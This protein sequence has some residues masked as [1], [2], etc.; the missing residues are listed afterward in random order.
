M[1][2]KKTV[3]PLPLVSKEKAES[4]MQEQMSA[5]NMFISRLDFADRTLESISNQNNMSSRVSVDDGRLKLSPHNAD[6]VW[7]LAKND[8]EITSLSADVEF[9]SEAE[10][11][12]LGL[13]IELNDDNRIE[14]FRIVITHAIGHCDTGAPSC[15]G[16]YT[17]FITI[18]HQGSYGYT[19]GT[20]A[21]DIDL[22]E[23]AQRPVSSKYIPPSENFKANFTIKFDR[24]AKKVIVKY[25]DKQGYFG[26]SSRF[27][28]FSKVRAKFF[29]E[30][31]GWHVTG[32]SVF[33]DNV[34]INN[35]DFDDFSAPTLDTTKWKTGKFYYSGGY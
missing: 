21:G 32:K 34:K 5:D 33:V 24:A 22:H 27:D 28:D 31:Q 13:L 16:T 1:T 20:L 29:I 12:G 11:S 19:D 2:L 6:N 23:S 7:L 10:I 25:G 30:T 3:E 35:Q 4:H 14:R 15:L 9:V 26:V 8:T 17:D 18:K